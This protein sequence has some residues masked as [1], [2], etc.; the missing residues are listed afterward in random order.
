[1]PPKKTKRNVTRKAPK[2]AFLY[3]LFP[4]GKEINA[5]SVNRVKEQIK[6]AKS[7]KL[8][9]VVH[10]SGGD[11]YSA[12][13]ISSILRTKFS[14]ITSIVPFKAMSAA[15]LML[16]GTDEI[17]MSEESQLG[18]LDLPMEHPLDGSPISALDVV[19]TLTQLSSTRMAHASSLYKEMRESLPNK[20]QIGK[21]KAIELALKF[22]TE[23]VK[24]IA[25]KIDPYHRQK[26]FRNLKIAQWYAFDLLRTGM[27]KGKSTRAWNTARRFVHYFPDHSYAI[28]KE[29]A[30]STL[31]LNIK[32]SGGYTKW[33]SICDE[34]DLDLKL[35]T[36][37]KI[38]YVEN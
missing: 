32:D 15:T 9:L 14:N 6:N 27:M 25:E 8:H 34:V 26:A 2:K 36:S 16:L 1:M 38:E 21:N 10:S 11:A 24:P 13:K 23:L 12:V 20:E 3:F 37:P 19:Q 17:Y 35:M 18:P 29:E 4:A 22:S 28:F 31:M 5:D 7:N 30:E 33:G